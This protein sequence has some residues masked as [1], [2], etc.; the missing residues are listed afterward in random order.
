MTSTPDRA[1]VRGRSPA[2]N[3]LAANFENIGTRNQST[4]PP[5]VSPLVRKLYPKSLAPDLTPRS[6]AFAARTA[7]FEKSRP[8]PQETPSSLGPSEDT[9]EAEEP[10]MTEDE[11]MSSIREDSKEEEEAEEEESSLPTFPYERLKTDSEDPPPSDIDLTRR[12]VR[13]FF[14]HTYLRFVY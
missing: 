3:A 8:T 14:K 7:L 11:S 6:A 1:R 10:K 4:P 12:E 5:M 9:N 2:F 13:F